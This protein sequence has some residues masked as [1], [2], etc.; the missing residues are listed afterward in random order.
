MI[1]KDEFDLLLKEISEIE[2]KITELKVLN[3]F[4]KANTYEEKLNNTRLKASGIVLD[5]ADR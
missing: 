5:T 3:K 4:D 1:N 2:K